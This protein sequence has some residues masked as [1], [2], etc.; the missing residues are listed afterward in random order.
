MKENIFKIIFIS[1]VAFLCIATF[2]LYNSNGWLLFI[3]ALCVVYVGEMKV[4]NNK[5]ELKDK[6]VV[7]DI[8]NEKE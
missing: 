5:Q 3:A 7:T 8:Y 2:A 6:K 1:L 4:S